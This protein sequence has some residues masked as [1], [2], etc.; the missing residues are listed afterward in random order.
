M[1]YE[2]ALH[3]AGGIV[4]STKILQGWI[5]LNIFFCC[6]DV[7][8]C[9]QISFPCGF[10]SDRQA[11]YCLA[12]IC[13][14]QIKMFTVCRAGNWW[15]FVVVGERTRTNDDTKSLMT[16]LS[17]KIAF[18]FSFLKDVKKTLDFFQRFRASCF[19]G[20]YSSGYKQETVFLVAPAPN[21]WLF[22]YWKNQFS[23]RL[24][25]Y[26]PKHKLDKK[27]NKTKWKTILCSI[28]ASSASQ[29]LWFKE[30]VHRWLDLPC[31]KNLRQAMENQNFYKP[32]N[33]DFLWWK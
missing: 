2:N 30:K 31:C 15:C 33:C 8:V 32:G 24:N 12:V 1:R 28:L 23:F 19:F 9:W 26:K 7:V 14:N 25:R 11:I 16:F 6:L 5:R 10:F 22:S 27:I 4:R 18:C 13:R 17:H 3:L 29:S 21:L 20:G